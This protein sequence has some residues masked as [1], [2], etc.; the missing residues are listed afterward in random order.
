MRIKI[1]KIGYFFLTT[2]LL[3]LFQ[4]CSE[5]ESMIDAEREHK[6]QELLS[7]SKAL[8]KKHEIGLCFTERMIRGG[9]DTLTVEDLEQAYEVYAANTVE[10]YVCTDSVMANENGLKLSRSTRIMGEEV[11]LRPED[12]GSILGEFELRW[13]PNDRAP[14]DYS[15][16]IRLRIDWGYYVMQG[17]S[18]VG[19]GWTVSSSAVESAA[20]SGSGCSLEESE[21]L[22]PQ[23]TRSI[24]KQAKKTMNILFFIRISLTIV[25][26]QREF[27]SLNR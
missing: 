1:F 13:T 21:P 7:I 27:E 24:R 5:E 17:I 15:G 22:P 2:F 19:S 26:K 4:S 16:V 10:F 11:L 9:I 25:L 23:L 12:G 3:L 18:E 8:A 14:I 6:V 20:G